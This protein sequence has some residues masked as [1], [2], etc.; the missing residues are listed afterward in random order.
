MKK[1]E[2]DI[3]I[4]KIAVDDDFT[5][6]WKDDSTTV[7]VNSAD[8]SNSTLSGNILGPYPSYNTGVGA[9]GSNGPYITT[10]NNTWGGSFTYPSKPSTLQVTGDAE[11]AGKVRIGGKDLAEFMDTI[12]KRL[13]ILVPDPAKLEHFEALKKAYNHYKVLEAL[14]ELP[15]EP[16][17]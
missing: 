2:F 12:S 4:Y 16:K 6:L 1:D 3:D 15:T 14:C 8:V 5:D 10:T 11:F 13:A 9:V 7:T 17:E